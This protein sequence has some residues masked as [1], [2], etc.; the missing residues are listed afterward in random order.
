MSDP[1]TRS[2]TAALG[3]ALLGAVAPSPEA[4]A[5][6]GFSVEPL[7][8]G[9]LLPEEGSRSE[10]EQTGKSE[11]EKSEGQTPET[12]GEEGK[13]GEGKCGEGKCGEGKCGAA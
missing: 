11:G 9:Y 7:A 12:K 2:L 10:Q 3:L 1:R 4:V 5:Q 6:G 8:R 13:C